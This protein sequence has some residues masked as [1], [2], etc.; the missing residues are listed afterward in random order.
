[1]S[2]SRL[3]E[4]LLTRRYAF[5]LFYALIVL[6]G[7]LS[8]RELPVEQLPNTE[9]PSITVSYSWGRT[10]P[11]VMEQEITRK[12]EQIA[13][14]LPGVQEISSQS[15]EGHS[16][17]TVTFQESVNINLA[18]IEWTEN[19]K[20][21][22]VSLPIEVRRGEM[23]RSVPDEVKGLQSFI[24]YSV[25]GPYSAYV[26]KE[27]AEERIQ[28]PL[29]GLE[30]I[31]NISING[32][33]E[34]VLT[35]RYK[36]NQW[37][38]LGISIATVGAEITRRFQW[39]GGGMWKK[40]G[41]QVPLLTKPLPAHLDSIRALPIKI[42]ENR[43]IPLGEIAELLIEDYP[44]T[45]LRRINGE[46][47]L[48]VEFVKE[49]GADALGLAEQIHER[50]QE[51][52]QTL[53]EGIV[54]RLEKDATENIRTEIS[55][56]T[57]Q[58]LYSV[59]FVF[60][61]LFVLIRSLH[62]P[63]IILSNILF[64]L[65]FAC[66]GLKV[67]NQTFNTFTMA[68]LTISIGMLVDNAIVVYEHLEKKITSKLENRKS[69]IVRESVHVFVPV[70][71]NTLTTV[72]IFLP[73]V[74]TIPSI[75]Y[76]LEPF[77]LALGLAITGSVLISMTWIPFLF[78]FISVKNKATKKK[79][80][81]STRFW[82]KAWIFRHR[83]R[84]IITIVVIVSIGLPF[85]LI[86]DF[87]NVKNAKSNSE[88]LDFYTQLRLWMDEIKPDLSEYLGGIGYRFYRYV[89]FS[90]PWKQSENEQL[91]VYIET[92]VGTPIEELDKIAKTFEQVAKPFQTFMRYSETYLNESSG[93]FLSFT[94]DKDALFKPE[95][96]MLKGELMYLAART[97]NASISVYG[98]GDGFSN[99]GFGGG[100]EF[101]LE[102]TGFNY[103]ELKETA[104]RLKVYLEK[105]SRVRNV[106]INKTESFQRD[107]LFQYVMKLDDHKISQMGLT[108][109]SVLTEIRS[110]I[111]ADG[112]YG[113]IQ[114]NHKPMFIRAVNIDASS[115]KEQFLN[116][117]R[118]ING[119]WVRLNEL[120]TVEKEKTLSRINRK[121]QQYTRVVSFEYLSSWEKGKTY[122]KEII[123]QFPTP[124]GASIQIPD[125]WSRFIVNASEENNNRWWVFAGALVIVLFI[126]AGLLNAWK[127]AFATLSFVLTGFIGVAWAALEFDLT[128]GRGAYAGVLLL[129]GVT[130]NN[131]ILLYHERLGLESNGVY[132][133]R[134]GL[135]VFQT[136][137][138][139]IWLTTLTTIAG[140]LPLLIWSS[141][142]FWSSMALIVCSGMAFSTVM[143]TLFWGTFTR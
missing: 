138:R 51:I 62:A 21:L 44:V 116:K 143:I 123:E 16:S 86:P 76:F 119:V 135:R 90:E 99:L 117:L 1:M 94:F 120:A 17:V 125:F 93:A 83:M 11:E 142:P 141:D 48:I 59:L 92:P 70:L 98:F 28:L 103:E 104:Q 39:L 111:A 140:L 38:Q 41:N 75:R 8:F 91:F 95:P 136:K 54:L 5:T 128:F 87:T 66:I 122:Q 40:N 88:E 52:Q 137:L 13:S 56:L 42:H 114:Y 100:N 113:R 12:V 50:L 112:F 130:V 121:N 20:V 18:Q 131:G 64:S 15:S 74:F 7:W 71:G 60:V 9:L 73:L 10:S 82:M 134:N 32:V 89:S 132:G 6:F 124:L 72:G 80:W 22:D 126:I 27:L 96:Y 37:N 67:F 3:F 26:L 35:I 79:P 68:A 58:A 49:T 2:G 24:S 139:S 101:S 46:R 133:L 109:A 107:D 118:F 102:L 36:A 85:Y 23:T 47:A 34:P 115:R 105:N 43:W 33:Q 78:Q 77:G 81:V 31:A 63:I 97:G 53:P 127:P 55:E 61:L 65:F 19:L 57:E 108:R 110:D 69:A 45:Y 14:R 129:G 84:W 30:G 25:S 29:S 4:H 106:D